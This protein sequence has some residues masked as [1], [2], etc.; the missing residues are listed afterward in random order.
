MATCSLC[1]APAT[2]TAACGCGWKKPL[3]GPCSSTRVP[4]GKL[5]VD[6]LLALHGAICKASKPAP[7]IS[8]EALSVLGESFKKCVWD[9]WNNAEFMAHYRRL[10]GH[11]LGADKRSTIEHLVDRATGYKPS[12]VD[13]AEAVEFFDFVRDYIWIP[14]LAKMAEEARG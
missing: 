11:A 14:V 12:S 10:T 13:E 7:S 2:S 8:P 3:C 6:H 4:N 9:C 1:S 5:M